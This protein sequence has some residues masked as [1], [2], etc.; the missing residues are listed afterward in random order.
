MQRPAAMNDARHWR[1]DVLG[2]SSH[3][4][5][6]VDGGVYITIEGGKRWVIGRFFFFEPSVRLARTHGIII[7]T[8]ISKKEKPK[9][10]HS[11]IDTSTPQQL[12]PPPPGQYFSYPH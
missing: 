11:D 12:E 8:H 3:P 7:A 10:P 5:E 1:S 2:A 4:L 9:T 6:L